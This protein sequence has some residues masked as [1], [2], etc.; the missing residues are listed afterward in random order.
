MITCATL[1]AG[2][3]LFVPGTQSNIGD[4]AIANDLKFYVSKICYNYPYSDTLVHCPNLP[5]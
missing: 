3:S 2:C 5:T 1:M 4:R